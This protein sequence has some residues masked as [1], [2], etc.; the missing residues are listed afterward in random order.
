MEQKFGAMPK[1][2]FFSFC[3]IRTSFN[4]KKNLNGEKKGR[5]KLELN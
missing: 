5:A 3:S 2:G 1:V 4:A